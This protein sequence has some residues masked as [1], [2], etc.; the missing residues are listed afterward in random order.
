MTHPSTKPGS[1]PSS[2]EIR[3]RGCGY[4][5]RAHDLGNRCPE[6]GR[7]TYDA[8]LNATPVRMSIEFDSGMAL[9]Q[10]S[11]LLAVLPLSG[12]LVFS[13]VGGVMATFAV[14]GPLFHITGQ[15]R[16]NR[17]P[18]RTCEETA[19]IGRVPW[20]AILELVVGIAALVIVFFLQGLANSGIAWTVIAAAW[21]AFAATRCA[22]WC[23]VNARVM[24]AFGLNITRMIQL[25]A[26]IALLPIGLGQLANT[27]LVISASANATTPPTPF[28]QN[29]ALIIPLAIGVVCMLFALVA[30]LVAFDGARRLDGIL[31]WEMADR[32]QREKAYL[33]KKP[34]SD[35]QPRSDPELPPLP[36]VDDDE[37][38]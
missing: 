23:L 10:W 21:P 38:R 29:T 35:H 28:W 20:T 37:L 33:R 36:L 8:R 15:W 14:F 3:C 1:P 6:C 32:A 5:L 26:G 30:C 18:F 11:L 19:P 2:H 25:V 24:D 12:L 16:F 9:V 34:V 22:T 31:H 27:A 4:D 13:K 7:S 17:S